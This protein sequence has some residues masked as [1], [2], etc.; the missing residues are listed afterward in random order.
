MGSSEWATCTALQSRSISLWLAIMGSISPAK[1]P[2]KKF[3]GASGPR[4]RWVRV[5]CH[6][7][8]LPMNNAFCVAGR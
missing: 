6:P 3:Y 5:S 4:K 7:Y 2:D 1:P 8:F